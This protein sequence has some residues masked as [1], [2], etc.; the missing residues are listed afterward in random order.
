MAIDE[1]LVCFTEGERVGD[2]RNSTVSYP[3]LTPL[4][5]DRGVLQVGNLAFQD[6]PGI[7]YYVLLP[8]ALHGLVSVLA[9]NVRDPYTT[10]FP[11]ECSLNSLKSLNLCS[12]NCTPDLTTITLFTKN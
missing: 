3:P 2:L 1:K 7:D 10:D 8:T 11:H 6:P 12:P 5:Q 4:R 9:A